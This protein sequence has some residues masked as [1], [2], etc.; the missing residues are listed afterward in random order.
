[1]DNIIDIIFTVCAT[2]AMIG[3]TALLLAFIGAG[4]YG[5]YR[6]LSE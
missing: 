5:L 2:V 1:M 4:I 6:M 3:L